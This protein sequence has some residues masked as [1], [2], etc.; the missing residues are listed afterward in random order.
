MTTHEPIDPPDRISPRESAIL[1]LLP[2]ESTE[3]SR[4]FEQVAPTDWELHFLVGWMISLAPEA[5]IDALNATETYRDRKAA[6]AA[7][8]AHR[9]AE[10]KSNLNAV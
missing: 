6:L 9:I 8:A 3:A 5:V 1:A 4:R 10:R 7:E 2:L